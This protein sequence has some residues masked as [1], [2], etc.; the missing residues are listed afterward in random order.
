VERHLPSL[1]A[2]RTEHAGLVDSKI[3]TLG[4]GYL[5]RSAP[6][7][8]HGGTH[9]MWM[10]MKCTRVRRHSASHEN[11]AALVRPRAHADGAMHAHRRDASRHGSAPEIAL[12]IKLKAGFSHH[13]R[14]HLDTNQ[15]ITYGRWTEEYMWIRSTPT[16]VAG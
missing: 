6:H 16:R 15:R 3:K 11:F 5:Q 1:V 7:A 13:E 4:L 14:R 9:A 8:N 10:R 2:A 12:R